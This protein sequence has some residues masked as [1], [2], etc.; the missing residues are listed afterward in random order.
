MVETIAVYPVKAAPDGPLEQ[1]RSKLE[2]EGFTVY[3]AGELDLAARRGLDRLFVGV[4]ARSEGVAVRWKAKSLVPGR[5]GDLHRLAKRVLGEVLG[6][7]ERVIS[8]GTSG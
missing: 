7:P 3:E 6:E 8:G 4:G 1:V 5:S 2:E